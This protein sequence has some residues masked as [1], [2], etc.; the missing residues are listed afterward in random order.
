MSELAAF[1]TLGPKVR[2]VGWQGRLSY[3]P[4]P[5]S[6]VRGHNLEGR[7]QA[8]GVIL[9]L[10]S[11]AFTEVAS[12][13][14]FVVVVEQAYQL[15]NG[16]TAIGIVLIVQAA[17]QV[18]FGSW[19]GGLTDPWGFRK[20]AGIAALVA[21]L[22]LPALAIAQ[23]IL[24]V[25]VLAFFFMLARLLLIPARFG[26]VSQV[27]DESS[28]IQTN[29]TVLIVAGAGSFIGPAIAAGR[30]LVF[31]AIEGRPATPSYRPWG[32]SQEFQRGVQKSD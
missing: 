2:E 24:V 31:A 19:A 7:P 5:S 10:L 18:I 25:Y 23:D 20:A 29:T 26:L 3:E 1:E 11:A 4:V 17:A 22:L 8:L 9:L 12:N 16:A 14:V 27:S 32:S 21:F 15:G 30:P 6:T 28:L 13:I